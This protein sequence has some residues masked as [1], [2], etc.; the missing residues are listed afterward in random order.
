MYKYTCTCSNP[1]CLHGSHEEEVVSPQ[2]SSGYSFSIKRVDTREES[3]MLMY[4]G[5]QEHLIAKEGTKFSLHL[6]NNTDHH[7]YV[8]V[9]MGGMN[10]GTWDAKPR[11][12]VI[13]KRNHTTKDELCFD[14]SFVHV[15]QEET[16]GHH[17]ESS[18]TCIFQPKWCE[19]CN[20]EEHPIVALRLPVNLTDHSFDIRR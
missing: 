1:R 13:V 11:T 8:T 14:R 6:H 12:T 18:I 15:N 20:R 4:N 9:Q 2:Q 7:S 17:V 5:N 3:I 19:T 10:L 16:R